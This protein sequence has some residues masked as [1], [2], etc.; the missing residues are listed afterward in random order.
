MVTRCASNAVS[1]NRR[2]GPVDA[3]LKRCHSSALSSAFFSCTKTQNNDTANKR[4][5][6]HRQESRL[7]T[8]AG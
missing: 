3:V 1:P 6:R 7:K 8:A 2:E 4:E 5:H